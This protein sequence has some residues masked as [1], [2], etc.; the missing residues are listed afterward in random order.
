[1]ATVSTVLQVLWF[2]NIAILAIFV[3]GSMAFPKPRILAWMQP[4]SVYGAIIAAGYLGAMLLQHNWAVAVSLTAPVPVYVF[5][6]FAV[7]R[8]R[9]TASGAK[10]PQDA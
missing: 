3:F 4:W 6:V 2:A 1:M 8:M 10:E 7:R 9:R 5:L